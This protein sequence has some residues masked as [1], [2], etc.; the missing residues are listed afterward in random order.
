MPY[1]TAAIT[2]AVAT[3]NI[4]CC[5]M[6]TVDIT[7]D[8]HSIK[9]PVRITLCFARCRLRMTAIWQP[10]ELYTCILGQRLVGVSAL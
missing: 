1:M 10:S 6:S 3:S 2:K 5:L 7:M 9:E 8:M 4:E